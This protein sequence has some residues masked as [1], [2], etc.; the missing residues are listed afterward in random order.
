MT[1]SMSSAA[2]V[3]SV[4]ALSMFSRYSMR[5]ARLR[6]RKRLRSRDGAVI[7][8]KRS[9]DFGELAEGAKPLLA[10]ANDIATRLDGMIKR[11]DE[12]VLPATSTDDLKETISKL[13]DMVDNGD[14]MVKNANDLLDQA[15][16]GQGV[17]GRLI[18]DKQVGD[19]LASFIANL[20]AHGP[21]FYKDDTADKDGKKK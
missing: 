17:L 20:K 11:L 9:V 18:N 4:T 14:T 12:D 2:P 10:K 21:V 6:I 19:N 3:F 16:H 15:K 5:K 1:P 8:G 13:R 7:Q